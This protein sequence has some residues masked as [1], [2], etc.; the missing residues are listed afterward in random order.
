MRSKMRRA[1]WA[2]TNFISIS[3]G[4][5]RARLIADSVI[6][7]N[8]TLKIFPFFFFFDF[9]SSS[10][11]RCQAI[12]SPSRSGSG[13]RKILSASSAFFLMSVRTFDLPLI[14]TYCGSKSCSR[15]TPSLL[16]GK[17][18]MWPTD[19]MTVYPRPRY[20]EIVLA[21]V[22]DST[23]IS[24]FAMRA[25]SSHQPSIIRTKYLEFMQLECWTS[26]IRHEYIAALEADGRDRTIL[27]RVREIP[28]VRH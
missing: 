24:D 2:L 14:V 22:G 27:A 28:L 20:F 17:S 23:M 9:P 8:K 11:S 4:D 18:L 13:A 1:C 12:A 5:W 26:L 6:S 25:P 21:F 3:P 10:C 7:L 19:A 15:S 16:V